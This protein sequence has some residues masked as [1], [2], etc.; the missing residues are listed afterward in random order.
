MM[1]NRDILKLLERQRD[2]LFEQLNATSVSATYQKA[3][4]GIASGEVFVIGD[5]K[6]EMLNDLKALAKNTSFDASYRHKLEEYL[7]LDNDSLIS[8]FQTE[9]ERVLLE[10]VKSGKQQDIQAVFIEYDYYYH[11]TSWIYCYGKQDYPEIEE[12]R[13]I[14][15]EYDYNKQALFIDNAINF[16]PAWLDCSVFEDLDYVE[17]HYELEDLFKLHSRTLL[18]KALDNL[19]QSNK[20]DI[21][22]NRPFT[23]Y[24][25][26]HDC[27]VMM[28]YRLG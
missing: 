7:N 10:I 25:N 21:L 18:H 24:I 16:Q 13:Y 1:N 15:N 20:L 9:L 2:I 28:L 4:D 19:R 27:E 6:E 5:N 22:H 8:Y 23:F 12:P 14:S 3:Y 17:I 11:Y 26:E